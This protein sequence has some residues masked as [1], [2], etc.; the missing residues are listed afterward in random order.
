M[1]KREYDSLN[2]LMQDDY[3]EID[4]YES[5]KEANDLLMDAL[6]LTDAQKILMKSGIAHLEDILR[7][8]IM[9]EIEDDE[10]KTTRS[11]SYTFRYDDRVFYGMRKISGQDVIDWIRRNHLE[12]ISLYND[13]DCL[14]ARMID[15]E[16]EKHYKEISIQ[17]NTRHAKYEVIDDVLEE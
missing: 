3:S 4:D 7:R 6:K 2:E 13:A 12:D 15:M 14:Y 17:W 9:N 10:P 8:Q 16:N 5:A 11:G 1:I